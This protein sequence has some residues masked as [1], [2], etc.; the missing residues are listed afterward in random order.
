VRIGLDVS[1]AFS[2][3]SG[4]R[5]YVESLLQGFADAGGDHEF[6]VYTAFW[7]DFPSRGLSIAVPNSPR[8]HRV[9][10][11]APQRL[12]LRVEARLGLRIQQRWLAPYQLD[13]FHGFA[14]ILPPLR[15]LRSVL[16]LYHFGM[17][18]EQHSKSAWNTFYYEERPR[19]S[20]LAADRLIACSEYT[21]QEAIRVLGVDPKKVDTVWLGGAGPEFRRPP[22]PGRLKA[23]GLTGPYLLFV[24]AINN[25]K[26]LSRLVQAYALLRAKGFPQ[27][28]ILVG[29]PDVS[30]G[31]LKEEIARLGLAE[32]VRFLEGVEQEDLRA[33]YCGADLFVYPS[34]VEGFGLPVIEAMTCG[35]PVLVARTSCLPEI[36]GDA[37]LYCEGTDVEDMARQLEKGLVDQDLRLEL[38]R[39]GRERALMFDWTKCARG[40]LATYQKVLS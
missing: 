17:E 5:R 39:K 40:T 11:R 1:G 26:N 30:A 31:P 10:K 27:S 34:L 12:L 35:V 29:R 36:A 7:G 21:R 2:K 25:R 9:L 15:G 38:V 28:L 8:F 24:S 14:S 13:V 16:S 3:P 32:D 20:T 37:A 4:M 22:E 18:M 23:L 19:V 6:F 33:L